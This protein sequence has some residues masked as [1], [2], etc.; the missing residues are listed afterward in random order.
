MLVMLSLMKY[1]GDKKIRLDAETRG[2]HGK[3][4]GKDVAGSWYCLLLRACQ[5]HAQQHKRYI[6]WSRRLGR[7]HL[8]RGRCLPNRA[9]AALTS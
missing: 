5:R 4:A 9:W 7:Y 3:N 2:P 1:Q 6:S 8:D